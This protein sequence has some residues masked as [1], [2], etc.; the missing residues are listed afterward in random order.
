MKI[1][2]FAFDGMTMFNLAA[3]LLIFGEVKRLGLARWPCL[4]MAETPGTIH[5]ADGLPV[6]IQHGLSAADDA[7]LVIIPAWYPDLRQSSP[8]LQAKIK[9]WHSRG[10]VIAGFC[11]GAFPLY[12][13]GIL[14]GRT[15]VAH[16]AALTERGTDVVDMPISVD[17]L[18]V[19]HG[20]VIT[21]AGSV[22]VFDACLHI[23]RRFLGQSAATTVA[24]QIV[25]PTHREGDHKQVIPLPVRPAPVRS[26]GDDLLA[27]LAV[28]QAKL[29]YAWSVEE[30]AALAN[31]SKRTFT[32]HFA[33][34]MGTTPARWLK[35][36]RITHARTLL[37][38]TQS[39]IT[40]IAIQCGFA[41]V[42]SF[43]QAFVDQ[44]GM[45]PTQYR[46]TF[47]VTLDLSTH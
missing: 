36:V 22:S 31:M 20:D 7:T 24:N 10:A 45:T 6:V 5:T 26:A 13:S 16:W 9:D 35:R 39:Q 2:V 40:A 46:S 19:D 29:A 23:V 15:M 41:H 4:T 3:P 30:M 37:E 12:E 18:Y 27:A 33:E 1:A 21:A 34:R 47:S 11:L 32:R 17:A 25:A 44:V 38:T 42:V 14:H 28:V 43:R 8:T